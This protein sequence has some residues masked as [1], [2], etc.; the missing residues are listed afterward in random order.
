VVIHAASVDLLLKTFQELPLNVKVVIEGEEEI[1]STHLHPFLKK[2][3]SKLDAEVLILADT[4]NFDSGVPGLTIAL[5]GLVEFQITVKALNKTI[6]SGM[7]GGPVPDAAM[8]LNKILATLV[9]NKGEIAV[10]GL[11][12]SIPSISDE[13]MKE[14]KALRCNEAEFREQCGMLDGVHLHKD[15][16]IPLLAQ[17][18]KKPSLTVNAMEAGSRKLAGNIIVDEAWARVTVRI[19][20]GMD[21]KMVQEKV[22]AHIEKVTP[23]GLNLE[24]QSE[25]GG[26]AWSIDPRTKENAPVFKLAEEALEKG[27][28]KKSIKFGSGGSIPFVGPFADTLGG[29][30]C[31]L[32]GLED[33]YTNAHG[34]NESLL[35]SDLKKAILSQAYL[36][37]SLGEHFGGQK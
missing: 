12:D 21:P 5:R 19:V 27:Y 35:V 22:R 1:G 28:G 24:I 8:G 32:I 15:P 7:W 2:F 10:A 29:V 4:C 13:E 3:R 23:W 34:E 31:L 9:D 11:C 33:P 25:G 26:G 6:H 18:W 36:F 30:P 16:H 17:L 14:L 37:Q 20:S